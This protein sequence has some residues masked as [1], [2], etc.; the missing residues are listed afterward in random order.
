MP[1]AM[2][3]IGQKAILGKEYNPRISTYFNSSTNGKGLN[4]ETN[5][6]GAFASW[7]VAQAGYAPP[8]L[9]CRAAM[10]QF[11]KHDKPIYGSL[12]VIDWNANELANVNG[13]DG[14]VGGVG[15]ITFVVGKSKDGK[16]FYCVG[17]NQGGQKGARTVKISKYSASDIDW[18]VIPPDYIPAKIEYELKIMQNDADVD[19]Q[20]STRS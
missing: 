12:A 6:C 3:E 8:P 15:H 2:G 7:V 19:S 11:W 14:A 4:E 10:W 18:F 20:S 13:K 5:W 9:S 16:F 17:G 1:F